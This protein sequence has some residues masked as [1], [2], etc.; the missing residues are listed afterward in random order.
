MALSTH[1]SIVDKLSMVL[2]MLLGRLLG[3]LHLVALRCLCREKMLAAL[4]WS[5]SIAI[6]SGTASQKT[7]CDKAKS[8]E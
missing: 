8:G 5:G 1:A 2:P 4:L 3:A 6:S 7:H